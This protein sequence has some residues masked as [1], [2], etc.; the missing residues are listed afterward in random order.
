MATTAVTTGH[1]YKI[2][3]TVQPPLSLSLFL[4]V[5]AGSVAVLANDDDDLVQGNTTIPLVVV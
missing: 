4:S 5:T 1:H 2:A 3:T